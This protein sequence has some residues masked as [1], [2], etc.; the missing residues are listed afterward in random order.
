M[1]TADDQESIF[2]SGRLYLLQ[3]LLQMKF[4]R[5]SHNCKDVRE[6]QMLVIEISNLDM[7]KL[8]LPCNKILLKFEIFN[9]DHN[10]VIK[11]GLRITNIESFAH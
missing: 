1:K 9:Y 10:G 3:T 5:V 2:L 4:L 6:Q 7:S 8:K 11:N